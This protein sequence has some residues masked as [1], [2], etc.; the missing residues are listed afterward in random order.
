MKGS[1]L[2]KTETV[3]KRLKDRPKNR[4]EKYKDGR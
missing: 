1:H 2:E 4:I 3:R